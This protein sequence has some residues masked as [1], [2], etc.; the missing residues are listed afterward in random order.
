[1]SKWFC[2]GWY[3]YLLEDNTGWRNIWCRLRGHPMGEIFFNTG[4]LEP[5]HRCR[6]CHEIIG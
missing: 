5:D 6:N 1:M 2:L 3:R 4:G